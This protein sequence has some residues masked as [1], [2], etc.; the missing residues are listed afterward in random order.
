MKSHRIKDSRWALCPCPWCGAGPID[1]ATNA[2]AGESKAPSVGDAGVCIY[3]GQAVHYTETGIH[4]LLAADIVTLPAYMR[5][6]LRLTMAAVRKM[7]SD[8]RQW[9]KRNA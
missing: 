7:P 3:C 2:T 1:G 8:V 4:K 6:Q 5:D 9:P